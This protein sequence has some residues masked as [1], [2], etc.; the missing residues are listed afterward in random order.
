MGRFKRL[1]VETVRWPRGGFQKA[2]VDIVLIERFDWYR[3][4]DLDG[5]IA[6]W[7]NW[8]RFADLRSRFYRLCIRLALTRDPSW[9][10]GLQTAGRCCRRAAHR[11]LV[12]HSFYFS[13]AGH[14]FRLVIIGGFRGRLRSRLG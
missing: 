7:L 1:F 4:P 8:E 11:C 5:F 6:L 10:G 2:L 12:P 3:A 9:L 14:V 13:P